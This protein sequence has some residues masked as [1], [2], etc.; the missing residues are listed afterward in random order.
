MLL[1]HEFQRV[2]VR[3]NI[4][5]LDS[6]SRKTCRISCYW[7][8]SCWSCIRF[9]LILVPCNIS[10]QFLENCIVRFVE[11]HDIFYELCYG[12]FKIFQV[13][14]STFPFLSVPHMPAQSHLVEVQP[15]Q[16][17]YHWYTSNS[18]TYSLFMDWS[19]MI[20][21]SIY[22]YIICLCTRRLHQH[23]EHFLG[24][25]LKNVSWFSFL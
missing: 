10:K 18:P 17:V 11:I 9:W 25:G 13:R 2:S 8:Y 22:Y 12:P 19:Y 14:C 15:T 4:T 5:R 6:H 3:C 16:C 1:I 23:V 21:E 24:V 7:L 20:K